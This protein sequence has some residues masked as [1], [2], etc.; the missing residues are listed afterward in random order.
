M[1]RLSSKVQVIEQVLLC[2]L[3]WASRR[4]QI[5]IPSCPRIERP[6]YGS[7]SHLQAVEAALTGGS[8]AN[9]VRACKHPCFAVLVERADE[10]L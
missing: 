4:Y 3:R 9:H 8:R 6:C 7:R 10:V 2:T 5:P 1:F